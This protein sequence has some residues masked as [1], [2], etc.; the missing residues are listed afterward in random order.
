MH[1]A[2]AEQFQASWSAV[3]SFGANRFGAKHHKRS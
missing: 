1:M 2:I 3:R